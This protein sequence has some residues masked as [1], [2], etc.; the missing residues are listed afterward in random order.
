MVSIRNYNK[1]LDLNKKL[2]IYSFYLKF[3]YLHIGL[4]MQP[5]M[6]FVLFSVLYDLSIRG[7]GDLN[8]LDCALN[9]Y[10]Y[11]R[12]HFLSYIL[13]LY[14]RAGDIMLETF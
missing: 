9:K 3:W 6:V 5:T 13:G 10:A 4:Y 8:T 7:S 2:C 14:Y 11:C 1:F 12:K